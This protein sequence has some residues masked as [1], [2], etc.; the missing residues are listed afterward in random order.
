MIKICHFCKKEINTKKE[1]YVHVEDWDREKLIK[2][3]WAH[4]NCFKKAMNRDL[5]ALEKQAQTMLKRAGSILNSDGFK[6]IFPE[7]EE[8]FVIT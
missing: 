3:I 5:T 4:L 1:K 2:E 6:E 8:E 7:K